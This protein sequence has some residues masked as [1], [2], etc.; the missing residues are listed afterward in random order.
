[1]ITL[2]SPDL[3]PDWQ[4]GELPLTSGEEAMKRILSPYLSRITSVSTVVE[5]GKGDRQARCFCAMVINDIYMQLNVG[6]GKKSYLHLLDPLEGVRK[7]SL[8][9]QSSGKFH[10]SFYS[11]KYDEV[12]PQL[13]ERFSGLL[14]IR[15]INSSPNYST[16]ISMA[17]K[18]QFT[19]Q[20]QLVFPC[21]ALEELTF[22]P[23][24]SSEENGSE[25]F[26]VGTGDGKKSYLQ[27]GDPMP[28]VDLPFCCVFTTE[29]HGIG[30]CFA[31]P[32]SQYTMCSGFTL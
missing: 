1:M 5:S 2:W 26:R 23:L 17:L 6:V 14:Q 13:F 8:S 3:F 4:P 10:G 9:F 7:L 20:N 21:P 29:K 19:L 30:P 31:G 15:Q 32:H 22:G 24:V 28:Q 25:I 11:L 12:M 16:E 27:K 18:P